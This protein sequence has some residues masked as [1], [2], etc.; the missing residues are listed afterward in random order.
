MSERDTRN[1]K[2]LEEFILVKDDQTPIFREIDVKVRPI[3]IGKNGPEFEIIDKDNNR[4]GIVKDDKTFQFD[5]QYEKE[6]KERMGDYYNLL[7]FEQEILKYDVVKELQKQD[8][9]DKEVE[10]DKQKNENKENQKET[11]NQKNSEKENEQEESKEEE[12]NI[13][14]TKQEL[15]EQI[16]KEI[17]AFTMIKDD[18]V[19]ED[20]ELSSDVDR[21]CVLIAE[22]EGKYKL[23]YREVGTNEIKEIEPKEY[24][25][26]STEEVTRFKDNVEYKENMATRLNV[27]SDNKL[28]LSVRSEYGQIRIDR[29]MRQESGEI[30]LSEIETDIGYPTEEERNRQEDE[31][32]NPDESISNESKLSEN[33]IEEI[34]N[35]SFKLN[36]EI[37]EQTKENIREIAYGERET[38][39]KG[40]LEEI[41][42][43]EKSNTADRET[44]MRQR[45]IN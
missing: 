36:N 31:R 30:I 42:E 45:K 12:K 13:P 22:I 23:L 29:V 28:E 34:I 5:I 4:I 24:E 14:I 15:E 38:I 43:E 21:N 9:R 32:F 27:N 1:Y 3:A 26:D 37:N 7:G 16:D 25:R 41:I 39:T 2:E 20:M 18:T 11:V 44:A 19:L 10:E 35:N 6:L 33:E 17:T 8:E 40:R